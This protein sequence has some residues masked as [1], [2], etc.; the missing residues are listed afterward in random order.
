MS[1]PLRQLGHAAAI[2]ISAVV[3]TNCASVR[4]YAYLERGANLTRYHTYN[5]AS[6]DRLSTGDPRLDNNSFFLERL[7]SDVERLLT[8]RGFGKITTATPDVWLH[9]HAS[10]DQRLDVDG[11][12]RK[13]G[14]CKDCPP[15]VYDAG[16][17]MLDFVDART[18]KLAW[19]GWAEGSLDGAIDN[20]DWME[21]RID[22]AVTRIL[23]RLPRRLPPAL[24][25]QSELEQSQ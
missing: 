4:V 1:D 23:T 25:S 6:D 19:R 21:Q 5:W 9:Y 20:Q 11:A 24:P 13:H 8:A 7:Q 3:L 12:D 10:I 15:T 2:A 18:N 14:D 16:T 17:L 22:E